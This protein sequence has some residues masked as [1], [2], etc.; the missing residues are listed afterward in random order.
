LSRRRVERRS[1]IALLI[2]TRGPDFKLRASG[3]PLVAD[4]GEQINVEFIGEQNQL[5]RPLVFD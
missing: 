1:Q 4:L 5:V 2:L 3:R